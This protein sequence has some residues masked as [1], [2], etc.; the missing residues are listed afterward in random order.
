MSSFVFVLVLFLFPF[1]G[2]ESFVPTASMTPS[3]QGIAT[4]ASAQANPLIAWIKDEEVRE[5][6][7]ALLDKKD[8][9][10]ALLERLLEEKDARIQSKD[11]VVE[12]LR[13]QLL[14]AKGLLTCRG[15]LEYFAEAFLKPHVIGNKK[16][17]NITEILRQASATAYDT[18]SG[19]QA[20]KDIALLRRAYEEAVTDTSRHNPDACKKFYA[21]LYG[22]LSKAIHGSSWSGPGVKNTYNDSTLPDAE[23]YVYVISKICERFNFDFE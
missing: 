20:A 18:T 11:D 2:V 15:V 4:S 10:K 6:V 21:G 9:E 23:A 1:L 3:R 14:E 8:E 22:E 12:L 19:S 7:N 17:M 16:R 5:F 13:K